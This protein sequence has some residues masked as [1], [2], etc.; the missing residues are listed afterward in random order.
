MLDE[1]R[2]DAALEPVANTV[3]VAAYLTDEAGGPV[4]GERVYLSSSALD[5]RYQAT[6]DA[7]GRALFPAVAAS[8]DYTVRVLP[9][10][11]YQDY[12]QAVA[13]LGAPIE[14]KL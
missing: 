14:I 11:P 7:D 8:G 1:I 5:T 10:G 2:L 13:D 9:R 4:A 3:A 12:A 6:S